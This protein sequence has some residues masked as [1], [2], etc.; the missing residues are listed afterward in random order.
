MRKIEEMTILESFGQL[1]LTEQQKEAVEKIEAFLSSSAH[2]FILK[3]YA[4]T[5]KTTVLEGIV[6]YCQRINRNA[7]LMAP[8]GRAARVITDKTGIEGETIHRTI[9]SW[10]DIEEKGTKKDKHDTDDLSYKFRFK[11]K[12]ND[13]IGN[14]NDA[15]LID[16][17]SM[18][19]NRFNA[20]KYFIF[21]TGYLLNDL[22][23][24]FGNPL[25]HNRKMIFVGDPA[26]L[27]PV[28]SPNSPA[29]IKD[30]LKKVNPDLKIMEYE[31]TKVLRQKSGSGILINSTSIRN[32]IKQQS[33]S[34]LGFDLNFQDIFEIGIEELWKNWNTCV[35]NQGLEETILITETNSMAS[36]LNDSIRDRLFTDKKILEANDI[37]IINRNNTLYGLNNGEFVTVI[38]VGRSV[39]VKVRIKKVPEPIYIRLTFIDLEIEYND[40]ISKTKKRRNVK[41]IGNLLRSDQRDLT[42]QEK[43]ALYIH[44]KLRLQKRGVFRQTPEFDK[45]LNQD[46]YFNALRVKYGYAITCHKAQGGEWKNAIVHFEREARQQTNESYFRWVYTAT[47]RAKENLFVINPPKITLTDRATIHP[48]EPLSEQK[49]PIRYETLEQDIVSP[50]HINTE[51]EFLKQ[52]YLELNMKCSDRG[53]KI[54]NVESKPKNYYDRYTFQKDGSTAR[55]DFYFNKKGKFT[56]V[57]PVGNR[58]EFL[59]EILEM[60]NLPVIEEK[61]KIIPYNYEGTDTT[62]RAVFGIIKNVV[63]EQ[64]SI[65]VY[66]TEEEWCINIYVMTNAKTSLLKV[67]HNKKG[68][69]SEIIP[70][71]TLGTDDQLLNNICDALQSQIS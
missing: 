11:I 34:N 37:L 12:N 58:N 46:M 23:T 55:V 19:S 61:R 21:G 54:I 65:I 29:L 5:G 42:D 39:S 27:P 8:T 9:Y 13:G 22:L 69:I 18:I 16:E 20:D 38:R 41:V 43:D 51:Y 63:E 33:F 49:I 68:F 28:G 15:Y 7:L 17:A 1:R 4:G 50:F 24:Y 60:N 59:A 26:Q 44:Y 71:S 57:N 53:I 25:H 31:L 6:R 35:S 36:R 70:K 66:M 30:E 62:K 32:A 52:K 56:K 40:Y 64:N 2:I 3:G 67:Y 48:V 47:T 14:N 10:D 45:E